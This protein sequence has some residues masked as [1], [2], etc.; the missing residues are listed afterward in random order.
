MKSKIIMF[1]LIGFSMIDIFSSCNTPGIVQSSTTRTTE[2]N[3]SVIHA[4]I[5]VD[6]TI[7]PKDSLIETHNTSYN[8]GN[9]YTDDQ[10]Q[11][12]EKS[13]LTRMS[14][15]DNADLIINPSYEAYIVPQKGGSYILTIIVKG[16]PVRYKNYRTMTLSDTSIVKIYKYLNM[17]VTNQ[18][19]TQGVYNTPPQNTIFRVYNTPPQNTIF[20]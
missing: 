11:T 10:I 2:V 14:L 17:N 12:Y 13:V 16:T 7:L 20:H 5:I 18:T 3:G 9:G 6:M 8:N 1:I 4:P 19:Q 15:K